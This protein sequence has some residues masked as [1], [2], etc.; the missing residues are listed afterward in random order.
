MH[1]TRHRVER[2]YCKV[3]VPLHKNDSVNVEDDEWISREGLGEGESAVEG[4]I[5]THQYPSLYIH[6]IILGARLHAPPGMWERGPKS[7]YAH[8]QQHQPHYDH[9]RSCGQ[10]LT[11]GNHTPHPRM[12]YES[13]GGNDTRTT[14][15]SPLDTQIHATPKPYP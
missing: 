11:G 4:C 9:Q 5:P 3:A 6:L 7:L 15:Q 13:K 8:L 12:R 10:V 1:R 2:C 14:L